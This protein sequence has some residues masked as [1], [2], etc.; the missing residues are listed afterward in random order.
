M[1]FVLQT[2]GGLLYKE[3][4]ENRDPRILIKRVYKDKDEEIEGEKYE[5]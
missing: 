4:Q 2:F 1:I 5:G 3:F